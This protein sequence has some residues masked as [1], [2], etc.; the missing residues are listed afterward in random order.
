MVTQEIRIKVT[1]DDYAKTPEDERWELLDGELIMAAAPNMK[2]Q[3]VQSNTDWHVQRF[4]R[5]RDLGRVFNA[6]TDVVLSEHDVVQPDLVFVSSE[7]ERIITDAN[8]QGAP[9][10]VVEILSPSTASRDWRDKLDLYARHGVAEYWLMDPISE[11]VW[12]FRLVDGTLVQV[13]MYGV[14]DTLTSP[15][16]EGFS[17]ELGEVFVQ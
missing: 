4:V 9:D 11:I 7:R 10:M 17:L 3:S 6:P 14:G 2:H 8:I 5:D 12:V 1:Y 15:L 13:G 16:L